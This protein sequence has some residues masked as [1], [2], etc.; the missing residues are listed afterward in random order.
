MLF[1]IER[2]VKAPD[3]L[4]PTEIDVCDESSTM[5]ARALCVRWCEVRSRRLRMSEI[6][7]SAGQASKLTARTRQSALVYTTSVL[8][9]WPHSQ[10]TNP[11]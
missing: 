7:R 2:D 3:V 8:W 11:G 10:P 5:P 4:A 9:R 1:P 6:K